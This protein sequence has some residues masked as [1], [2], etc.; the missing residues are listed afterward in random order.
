MRYGPREKEAIKTKYV[1]R[2]RRTSH[3]FPSAVSAPFS[4][5]LSISS[6]P[7]P[8]KAYPTAVSFTEKPALSFTNPSTRLPLTDCSRHPPSAYQLGTDACTY[9]TLQ[10][11]IVRG[12]A[13]ALGY[14]KTGC[15]IIK[16]EGPSP[17]DVPSIS[18]RLRYTRTVQASFQSGRSAFKGGLF[19]TMPTHILTANLAIW[20]DLVEWLHGHRIEITVVEMST[21]SSNSP[22]QCSRRIRAH[23]RVLPSARD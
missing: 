8:T 22:F 13:V 17:M 16:N 10:H 15:V 20:K 19:R 3:S 2:P 11:N 9:R 5:T 4:H 18:H 7:Q 21:T 14:I 12:C 1:V 23:S 6:S